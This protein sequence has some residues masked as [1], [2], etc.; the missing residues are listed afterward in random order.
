MAQTSRMFSLDRRRSAA[1]V[2]FYGLALVPPRTAGAQAICIGDCNRGIASTCTGG[3]LQITQPVIAELGWSGIC[4][5]AGEMV[6]D[7]G[8][9]RRSYLTYEPNLVEFDVGFNGTIDVTA[10]DCL[11]PRFLGCP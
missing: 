7:F 5:S 4:P 6:A 8:G 10:T 1:I 2:V 9:D 11:D 3:N